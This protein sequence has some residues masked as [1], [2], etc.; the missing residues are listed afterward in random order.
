MNG[1]PIQLCRQL[2]LVFAE[3]LNVLGFPTEIL[4][5]STLD[6]DIQAQAAQETGLSLEDLRQRFTRFLPLYHAV[7]KTFDEPWKQVAG[8]FVAV[9]TKSLTPL[10][11]SLIFAGK[12]L[13]RR[14]EKRKVLLCLTDGKPVVGCLDED[15]TLQH[16]C[17]S[18]RRLTAAGIEPVGLGIKEKCVES[19]FPRSAV[20]HTLEELP[21]TFLRQLTGVLMGR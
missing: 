20:I 14:P 13:I 5:F 9:R 10:G 3:S 7:L 8:R 2:A 6:N 21:R 12:R 18:V 19:I 15:I 4:G 16:A 17:D 11:E 1:A